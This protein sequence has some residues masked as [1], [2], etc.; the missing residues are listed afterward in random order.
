MTFFY[1]LRSIITVTLKRLWA[2]RGITLATTIGLTM[3]PIHITVKKTD[4]R[5]S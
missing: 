5:K 4:S 2:Q 3:S 1:R